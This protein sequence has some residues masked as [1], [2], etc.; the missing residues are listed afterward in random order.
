MTEVR[1]RRTKRCRAAVAGAGLAL[2]I[3]I[4][5]AAAEAETARSVFEAAG[6][7]LSADRASP[8]SPA[9]EPR[10]VEVRGAGIELWLERFV[11]GRGRSYRV[12]SGYR[13]CGG[14]RVGLRL[15]PNREVQVQGLLRSRRGLSRA[16]SGGWSRSLSDDR[17]VEARLRALEVLSL[18]GAGSVVLDDRRG[19]LEFAVVV[20]EPAFDLESLWTIPAAGR[21]E[22][23]ERW[24]ANTEVSLATE[25]EVESY[26]F[27]IAPT[28][29]AFLEVKLEHH[30][31]SRRM[32]LH[33]LTSS[34]WPPRRPG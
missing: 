31:C 5:A 22:L 27:A 21:E 14:D 8:D 12:A 16:G 26:A 19:S 24:A 29:A 4:G 1:D 10:I 25:G 28:R 11:G 32:S 20:A 33:D 13:F 7:R 2:G 15:R 9:A 6:G 30:P 23:F 3:A 34:R 17:A 18:P